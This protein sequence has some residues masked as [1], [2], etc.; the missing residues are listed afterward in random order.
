MQGPLG[1]VY[2]TTSRGRTPGSTLSAEPNASAEASPIVAVTARS[3]ELVLDPNRVEE[4]SEIQVAAPGGWTG[5]RPR[6]ASW[7]GRS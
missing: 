4:G 5:W 1:E 7:V 6:K 2:S 3:I